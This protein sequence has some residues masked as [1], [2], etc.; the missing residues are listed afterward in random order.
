MK[1]ILSVML[2]MA[3]LVGAVSGVFV[4]GE[5]VEAAGLTEETFYISAS[6]YD[7]YGQNTAWDYWTDN[8]HAD[9]WSKMDPG[10]YEK[11]GWMTAS[12]TDKYML[13]ESIIGFDISGLPEDVEV[14]SMVVEMYCISKSNDEN[15]TSYFAL[16]EGDPGGGIDSGDF[17]NAIDEVYPDPNLLSALVEYDDVVVDEWTTFSISEADYEYMTTPD[18]NGIAW[19]YVA[20]PH[21]I[22]DIDPGW[23]AGGSKVFQ[24]VWD[25]YSAGATMPKLTITYMGGAAEREPVIDD[26]A[27]VDTNTDGSEEATD[28]EWLTPRCAY[29]DE[30]M[31]FI[32]TGD[33]GASI[34]L[35]MYDGNGVELASRVDSVRTD[36]YYRWTVNLADAWQGYVH[37]VEENHNLTC[38]WG[39][40]MP[41]PDSSQANCQVYARS[42]EYP[43]YDREWTYYKVGG[44]D[45]MFLHYKTNMEVSDFADHSFRIWY[46]GGSSDE[47]YNETFDDI[48][49]DYFQHQETDND[50]M[51]HWRYMLFVMDGT[52]ESFDD[53]D[54]L[55][56][57][58]SLDYSWDTAGFY[59]AL[60]YDDTGADEITVTHSCYWYNDDEEDGVVVGL[61]SFRYQAAGAATC[62]V[63]VGDEC[64]VQDEL[65]D[66]NITVIAERDGNEIDMG[67]FEVTG[68][69]NSYDFT[70]PAGAGDY[71]AR[72]TFTGDST[73]SY[74]VQKPCRV[75]GGVGGGSAGDLIGEIEDTIERYGL[76]NSVGHW[77]ILIVL[78]VGSFLMLREHRLLRIIVPLACLAL[79]IAWSWV[80]VWIVVL[81]A[82]GAGVW[83]VGFFKKRLAGGAA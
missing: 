80:D 14:I 62:A 65:K 21:H 76:N 53:K 66:L 22:Y 54:G 1:R 44:S 74:I 49:D 58:L 40:V 73:F 59:Q 3:L 5:K 55:I 83:L 15:W 47:E 6:G 64:K 67:N 31:G 33:S 23:V 16:W 43:Q 57:V 29:A 52:A 45:V 82:L 9:T 24:A 42:T 34:S 38:E 13:Y 46:L 25:E 26:N 61:N 51:C 18:G 81:L 35:V 11:C 78:M 63:Y 19:V 50:A 20:T 28:V 69:E 70:M 12:T 39:Y 32:V 77:M 4:G 60:V 72:L 30:D 27:P 17:D 79:G 71:W 37:V 10:G 2:I 41:R 8:A 75:G 48:C 36:G 7:A 56:Q 68:D